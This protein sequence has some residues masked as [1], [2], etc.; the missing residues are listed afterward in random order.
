MSWPRP[1][2]WR[3]Y[4]ITGYLIECRDSQSELLRSHINGTE[5]VNAPVVNQTVEL[6]QDIPDFQCSVTASNNLDESPSSITNISLPLSML[7]VT[8]VGSFSQGIIVVLKQKTFRSS[9]KP[10]TSSRPGEDGNAR[11]CETWDCHLCEGGSASLMCQLP[12]TITCQFLLISFLC[13]LIIPCTFLP[14]LPILCEFQS[15]RY[16][17]VISSGGDPVLQL[18]RVFSYSSGYSSQ[19]I[20]EKVND[21]LKEG[22]EYEV[23]VFLYAGESGNSTS[24]TYTFSEYQ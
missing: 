17:V 5:I 23:Q 12:G 15:V 3:D 4:P 6:P 11:G 9:Y 14:Q 13:S 18:S 1:F 21:T 10:Q 20:E 19:C 16:K 22:T 8:Y 24:D 2:T 7:Y